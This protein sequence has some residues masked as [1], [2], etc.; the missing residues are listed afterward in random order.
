LKGRKKCNVV[1]HL[2]TQPEGVQVICCP[3]QADEEFMAAMSCLFKARGE[4]SRSMLASHRNVPLE[5]V[6][7]DCW[8]RCHKSFLEGS[9]IA[10]LDKIFETM[11]GWL[12][13]ADISVDKIHSQISINPR[14]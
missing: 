3:G 9:M 13:V 1:R 4:E 10:I 2:L 8:K 12:S 11:R 7:V 6:R 14:L 5:G